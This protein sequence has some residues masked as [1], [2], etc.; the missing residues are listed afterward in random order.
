MAALWKGSSTLHSQTELI[1]FVLVVQDHFLIYC[2]ISSSLLELVYRFV[3]FLHCLSASWGRDNLFYLCIPY[4]ILIQGRHSILVINCWQYS[5]QLLKND[6]TCN[7][8]ILV[9]SSESLSSS[10][11]QRYVLI[12][13]KNLYIC[14][15]HEKAII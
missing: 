1:A 14:I 9:I 10:V 13:I 4:Y 2:Y 5:E 11:R 6:F 12:E 3:C 15:S 7:G 8:D